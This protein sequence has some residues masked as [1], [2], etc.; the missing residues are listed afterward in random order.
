MKH[1]L[2]QLHELEKKLRD[3]AILLLD[4]DGTITPI[5]KRPELA[6]LPSDMGRLLG[7]LTR[8]F[9]V[10]IISGRSLIEV[11]KLVGLRRVYYV[12]NH[13]LEISGPKVRIVKH[14]AKRA[15]PIIAEV[16]RKLQKKT[17]MIE[18]VIVEDKGLTASVHYRLVKKDNLKN[19]KKIFEW[20]VKPHLDSG[21]IRVT[22]GKKV[23]EIRPNIEWDKGK[24]ILWIID[25]IDPERKLI[26][27]Y[28]G[29][30]QTDEDAFSALKSRGITI[31]VSGK[32]KKSYAKFFLRNV[33]EVKTFLRKLARC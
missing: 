14:E 19:L 4:Y 22:K 25:T 11:K 21:E 17:M 18:G 6:I 30:D 3:G 10:A 1:L 31:L 12:G 26:P 16:H 5:V 24:A 28:I 8:H 20:I 29:D 13:G 15:R 2:S 7:S 23:F 27:V 32:P 9:K 33:D